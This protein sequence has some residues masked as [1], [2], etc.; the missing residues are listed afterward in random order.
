MWA[1]AGRPEGGPAAPRRESEVD[2]LLL[3]RVEVVDRDVGA[4]ASEESG[5]GAANARVAAGDDGLLALELVRADVL[6]E[7]G[8]AAVPALDLGLRASVARVSPA[9]TT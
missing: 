7:A 8:L 1:Q 5:N 3:L 2:A 6:L 9:R 4:L